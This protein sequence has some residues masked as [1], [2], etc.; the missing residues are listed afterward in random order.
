[1]SEVVVSASTKVRTRRI[2]SRTLTRGRSLSEGPQQRRDL[3]DGD[4]V[5]CPLQRDQRRNKMKKWAVNVSGREDRSI[6]GSSKVGVGC[7]GDV[8]SVS[9]G[10]GEPSGWTLWDMLIF[11]DAHPGRGALVP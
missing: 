10:V 8:G 1:M 9:R 7:D 5:L 3:A 6:Q 11:D 4:G 2:L